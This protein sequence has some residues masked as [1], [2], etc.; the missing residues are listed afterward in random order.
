MSL[1]VCSVDKLA[2]DPQVAAFF[3][4]QLSGEAV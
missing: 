2:I 1:V 3:L 4:S